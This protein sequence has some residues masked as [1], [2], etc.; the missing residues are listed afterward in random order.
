MYWKKSVVENNDPWAD[1]T[2]IKAAITDF[3]SI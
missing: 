2:K 1:V 3:F